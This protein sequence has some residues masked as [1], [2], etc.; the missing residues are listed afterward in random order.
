MKQIISVLIAALSIIGAYNT[1]EYGLS[2]HTYLAL[3]TSLLGIVGSVLYLK[4][5]RLSKPLL[6]L[7]AIVQIPDFYQ[8]DTLINTDTMVFSQTRTNM[9]SLHQFLK[10]S[11]GLTLR[12]T[13]GATFLYFN[14]LAL[15]YIPLIY[16]L[17]LELL[18]GKS[19]DIIRFYDFAH[20]STYHATI[21]KRVTINNEK[22]W[23]LISLDKALEFENYST[24]DFMITPQDRKSI[25]LISATEESIR[26][27]ACPPE[28]HLD[29][30]SYTT[31]ELD[32]VGFIDIV[33]NKAS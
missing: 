27:F 33:V 7:W 12:T 24:R 8:I 10:F 25:K 1:I 17:E 26:L 11:F 20:E 14:L 16:W 21:L 29:K 15:A 9:L 30:S 31:E 13:T 3:T 23:Y 22:D 19:F 5:N 18:V 2:I 28:T 32:Y 6:Y 4:K